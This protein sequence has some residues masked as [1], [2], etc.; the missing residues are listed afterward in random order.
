[1]FPITKEKYI[2]F[3]KYVDSTKN[4]QKKTCVKLHFIDSCK[5]F[6]SSLEKLASYLDK[7]KL[8][9]T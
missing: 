6:A 9:I 1:M 2:S 5:F 4:E 3:T 8:K 7:D